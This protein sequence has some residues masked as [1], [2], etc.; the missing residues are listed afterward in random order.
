[1]SD[2]ESKTKR[3]NSRTNIS[4]GRRTLIKSAAVAAPVVLTLRSGAVSALASSDQCVARDQ[5]VAGNMGP[6]RNGVRIAVTDPDTWVRAQ[7][8]F[9][10]LERNRPNGTVKKVTVYKDPTGATS[11]WFNKRDAS[12]VFRDSGQGKMKRVDISNGKEF[13]ITQDFTGYIL[14]LFDQQGN[15]VSYGRF[16]PNSP[17]LPITN[18]CWASITP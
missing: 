8:P 15:I 10:K 5:E 13:D 11:D 9:R 4:Q 17:P 14:V 2:Q 3:E 16:D 6:G 1:M 12:Q 18:S 7:T